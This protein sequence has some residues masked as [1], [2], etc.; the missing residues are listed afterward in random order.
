MHAK[1]PRRTLRP[2][3]RVGS[4]VTGPLPPPSDSGDVP[5]HQKLLNLPSLALVLFVA[6]PLGEAFHTAQDAPAVEE[7]A[8]PRVRV[9]AYPNVACPIMGKPI[10]A[11]LFVDTELGRFWVCCKGC[12]ED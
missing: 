1:L 11:R 6:L 12:D 7:P 4:V 2:S 10:S 5:M 8:P 3:F 9:P